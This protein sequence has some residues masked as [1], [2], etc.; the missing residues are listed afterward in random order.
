MNCQQI[1]DKHIS[2][3]EGIRCPELESMLTCL[4][5]KISVYKKGDFML[6]AGSP[7]RHVGAMM[8]GHA[9]VSRDD[10]LGNRTVLTVLSPPQLFAES[11]V[12]AGVTTSP[13]NV[14]A[15]TD[16]EVLLIAFDK[17]VST[18]SSC[19]G[20]HNLL[21]KNMMREV[22]RKNLEMSEK[23]DHLSRKTTRQ[24]IASFLLSQAA[25]A[26]SS[27]FDIALDRQAL[28]DYLCVNRSALSRELSGL[29][30]L[31]LINYHRSSFVIR[32][33]KGL[34]ALLESE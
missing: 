1:Y 15:V 11:L 19:C 3:F 13:V 10:I 34:Q 8:S 30:D 5:A 17:I 6:T 16:A 33:T 29:S 20:H 22:A 23:L 27:R 12:C 14:E 24:K 28:A 26:G 25:K 9:V 18:C 2:L 4:G 32:N 21:I 7:L 31:G